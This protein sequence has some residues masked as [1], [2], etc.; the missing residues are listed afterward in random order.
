MTERSGCEI[1]DKA[2]DLADKKNLGKVS[3]PFIGICTGETC[4]MITPGDIYIAPKEEPVKVSTGN[5]RFMRRLQQTVNKR[6]EL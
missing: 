1:V 5:D 4:I 6:Y 2:Q 3:C